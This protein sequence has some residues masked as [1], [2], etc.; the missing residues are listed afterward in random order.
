M[1]ARKRFREESVG[2][3]FCGSGTPDRSVVVDDVAGRVDDSVLFQSVAALERGVFQHDAN[4]SIVASDP[5]DFLESGVDQ[6]TSGPQSSYIQRGDIDAFEYICGDASLNFAPDLKQENWIRADV[7][8]CPKCSGCHVGE[9]S[10]DVQDVESS[11]VF[12]AHAILPSRVDQGLKKTRTP[13][14]VS[15]STEIL[16]KSSKASHSSFVTHGSCNSGKNVD[17]ELSEVPIEVP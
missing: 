16:L 12:V 9:R 10:L 5:K 3:E 17:E 14:H 13:V 6:R 1:R 2:F 4:R 15:P 8:E 7:V 11:N